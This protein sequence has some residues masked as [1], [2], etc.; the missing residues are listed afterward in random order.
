MLL[1][2]GMHD[3]LVPT[4]EEILQLRVLERILVEHLTVS[5]SQEVFGKASNVL[6]GDLREDRPSTQSPHI[7]LR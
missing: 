6:I 1:I 7:E 4:V 3:T 2:E 5:V